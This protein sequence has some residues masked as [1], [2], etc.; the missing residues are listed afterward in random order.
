VKFNKLNYSILAA[1][2]IT[3][4][5]LAVNWNRFSNLETDSNPSEQ[6]AKTTPPVPETDKQEKPSAI[7]QLLEPNAEVSTNNPDFEAST[8]EPEDLQT[9]EE[10]LNNFYSSED[11]QDREMALMDVGE[12]ADPKAKEAIL[13]ALNDPE[14]IVREQAVGQ[15]GNWED[16]KERQQMLLTALN[17]DKS[18]IVVLA[19]ESVTELDDPTLLQKVK[20]LSLDKNEDVSEAAKAALE[21]SDEE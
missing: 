2:L 11:A 20:E 15:I 8:V 4:V 7:T 21:M 19:L 9:L 10:A 3:A 12:Y 1:I 14:N 17:N 13:Y 5:L 16:E 6:T 18:E